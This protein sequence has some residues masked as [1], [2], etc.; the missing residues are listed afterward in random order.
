MRTSGSSETTVTGQR[1]PDTSA[2]GF[3]ASDLYYVLFR[4][5]WKI[6]TL[7]VLG[8][9][10]ATALL[11]VTRPTYIS[12]SKIL[13]R[14]VKDTRSVTSDEGTA[15][16]TPGGNESI[17]LSELEILSSQQLIKDVV[18]AIG[19][20]NIVVPKASEDT[21]LAAYET[22][23]R[24][25]A[26]GV[27]PRSTVLEV[28]FRHEDPNLARSVLSSLVTNYLA[29][30]ARVHTSSDAL[31][32][33]DM[34]V[35][36]RR[37]TLN[38]IESQLRS[39]K[40]SLGIGALDEAQESIREQITRVA[41]QVLMTE[42]LLIEQRTLAG[43]S[44]NIAALSGSSSNNAAAPAVTNV[45]SA[46]RR[47][48]YR[49]VLGQIEALSR[50]ES[51]LLTQF[52][53]ASPIV[54]AVKDLLAEADRKRQQLEDENPGI[55]ALVNPVPLL[56][57]GARQDG[58]VSVAALAA[59]NATAA[60]TVARSLEAKLG[61]L[62]SQLAALQTQ[63]SR[64]TE[65]AGEIADLER[66][67]GIE[68]TQYNYHYKALSQ[69]QVDRELEMDKIGGLAVIEEATP[70]TPERPKIIKIAAALAGG[71]FALGL[72]LA[73]ALEFYIDQTI[74]RPGQVET[75]LRLPLFLSIPR[76]GSG[77]IR[78]NPK[79]LPAPATDPNQPLG[80]QEAI[81]GPAEEDS[82]TLYAEAL[83]DR[84]MMHFQLHGLNHKPKLVGVTSCAS[85]AG[86][87]SLATT[88]AASL[89]ETGDGN[90]LYVD[91][92]Q[93]RGP[94]ALPFQRGKQGIGIR[95]ALEEG[96]RDAARVQD[97]LYMVG[98]ADPA[99][100]KVGIIPRTL[101]GLVPK[102]KASDY[103]YII[104]DL[105]PISQTSA[106]AKVA[107]LLDMTFVVLES[108]KTL[109][110]LA[111]KA[112]QLLGESRANVAAVLNKHERYL[113]RSLDGDL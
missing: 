112:T 56:S 105:P 65:R 74:R 87:T 66:R 80:G 24:G 107:G 44:T 62:R 23:R 92:N 11:T 50:R 75:Q 59:A 94:S 108:E 17:I 89:S 12:E 85:G 55:A 35:S 98:L 103:D 100:G 63:S 90:V 111:K 91:V 15:F 97:N 27:A 78:R 110:D 42:A 5:K 73:F 34:K 52:T 113:P 77:G 109:G 49:S 58:S 25:L 7:G 10:A 30:H 88:L 68:E 99:S 1:L 76:L 39:L 31:R 47:S 101:A 33:A 19:P 54:K 38:A 69:A 84:L 46:A 102:M 14:Y 45:I 48:E 22:I 9:L 8:I 4:H 95:D 83:R 43:Q 26:T 64:I 36:M 37:N 96:T 3:R 67:K 53:D 86:V 81:S 104:F 72:A 40:T 13:I 2:S 60:A 20:T 18:T 71:G 93:S 61:V 106:T 16:R 79:A 51:D 21:T 70:A 29:L 82:M 57:S 28:S 6:L 41:E 32:E